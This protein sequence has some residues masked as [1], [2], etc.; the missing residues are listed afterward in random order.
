[1]CKISILNFY[2]DID[3]KFMYQ[4]ASSLFPFFFKLNHSSLAGSRL[5]IYMNVTLKELEHLNLSVQF[6]AFVFSSNCLLHVFSY[7]LDFQYV[8]TLI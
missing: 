3:P 8:V 1:M 6:L 4:Y 2:L 7:V 5:F